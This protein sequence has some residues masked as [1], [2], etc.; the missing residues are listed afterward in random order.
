M[1][2]PVTES[3]PRVRRIVIATWLIL[4]SLIALMD[5]IALSRLSTEVRPYGSE[6][7]MLS[8]RLLE[9]DQQLHSLANQPVSVDE[10][11]FVAAQ[12]TL[13]ARIAQLEQAIGSA[14]ARDE[15][16]PVHDRLNAVETRLASLRHPRATSASRARSTP[17]TV[18]KAPPE[19]VV[20]PFTVLGIEWRGGVS[21]LSVAPTSANSLTQVQVLREGEPYGEWRLEKLTSTAAEFRVGDRSIRL[22]IPKRKGT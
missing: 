2:T 5:H 12:E 15:L 17:E 11:R 21:F 8:V 22:E 14:A 1:T 20:P 4:V 9:L 16:A 7:S 6:V 18:S 3:R 13:D 19:V 10:A